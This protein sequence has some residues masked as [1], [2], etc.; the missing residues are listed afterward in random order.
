[1]NLSVAL[2]IQPGT[3]PFFDPNLGDRFPQSVVLHTTGEVDLITR[4][5][6]MLC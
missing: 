6:T 2:R 4:F 3:P 1:M 5:D